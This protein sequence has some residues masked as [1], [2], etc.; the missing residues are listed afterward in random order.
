MP[1][2]ELS[3]NRTLENQAGIEIA[4]AYRIGGVAPRSWGIEFS[5]VMAESDGGS[6]GYYLVPVTSN[7]PHRWSIGMV[8]PF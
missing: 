2:C 7:G 5:A 3:Q 4:A 8:A 1:V 6:S